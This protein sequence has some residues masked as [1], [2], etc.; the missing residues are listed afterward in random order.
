[1]HRE[2]SLVSTRE[3]S[4]SQL[5]RA[6]FLS[7]GPLRLKVETDASVSFLYSSDAGRLLSGRGA[8]ELFKVQAGLLV[9]LRQKEMKVRLLSTTS[10]E[11]S[12]RPP[13][14]LQ[15]SSTISLARGPPD[16]YVRRV[17]MANRSVAPARVRALT[18]CDPTSLNFRKE[19]DPPGEIGLNAFNRGDHV[20]MD[21]VGDTAGARVVGLNP[22]PSI[23]YMTRERQRAL[24]L[25][26]TGELPE[27]ISGLSGPVMVLA[28]Q[29][30]DLP[31]GGSAELCMATLYDGA[32][33]GAALARL[34]DLLGVAPAASARGA[35]GGDGAGPGTHDPEDQEAGP[36]FRCSSPA[37]SS[38]YL[39]AKS[40]L[41]SIEGEED[42]F[43]RLSAGVA[44]GLLRPDYFEHEF[45]AL[46]GG[47][48]K[49][50]SLAR[51]GSAEQGVLETALFVMNSCVY[52]SQKGDV[53]LTKRWYP[54]LK[55]AGAALAAAA[56]G[57]LVQTNASRP[58]G[59]RR[60]LETGFPTGVTSEVNLIVARALN[61][62]AAAAYA[63]GRGT[64]SAGFRDANVK[65]V[66]SINE[67][68]KDPKTGN[69]VLNIDP[70]GRV[71]PEVT[72]DQAV[73][74]YYY[75]YDHNLASSA[76]QR[77]LEK[78]F[79]SGLGPR[80]VPTSNP[81]YYHP[82]YGEG[83]LGSCWT[84]VALSHALLAYDSGY[85]S[86][87][88]L[89]LEKV[90]RVVYADWEKYGGAPGEFPYWFVEGERRLVGGSGSDPVAAAR[91][92]EAVVFGELG[93]TRT[94]QG[95]KLSPPS[96]SQLRWASMHA[97][98]LGESGSLF[99]GRS[100]GRVVLI[101]SSHHPVGAEGLL[102][103]AGCR[104][105]AT[106]APVEALAFWDESSMLIC[107][108]TSEGWV[109]GSGPH[110]FTLTVPLAAGLFSSSLYVDLQEFNKDA[111]LWNGPER[112]RLQ[113]DLQ[114]RVEL[115]PGEWSA[116]RLA[117]ATKT[118]GAQG[119]A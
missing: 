33:L 71:H 61:E 7:R 111:R 20:V 45:D 109:P 118:Q 82:T 1:M 30:V 80:C 74:L 103:F 98:T 60:R 104:R 94:P 115:V 87:G 100:S 32:S 3:Y 36:V 35:T 91:F 5:K 75:P 85:P 31:P 47:Q 13:D 14:G 112:R 8:V 4:N 12:Y 26:S 34:P 83:Q 117:P 66:S 6:L 21:D 48:R 29:D 72:A 53:K 23:I 88:G 19:R 54:S 17:S 96:G 2:A 92:V 52:L 119:K 114:I 64:D 101:A 40:A 11:F 59:W 93:V 107:A 106:P 10:V 116:Y 73:G 81:L 78:D 110:S 95:P 49:D 44:L 89:Q 28:Q 113:G 24:D 68:L 37:V 38:A 57:G 42:E 63:A 39:W 55:K 41:H 22:R 105:L 18:I 56:R 43:E 102:R 15:F 79:E 70:K 27:N 51:Q 67:R 108:G 65:M 76:V 50:G 9:P 58:E 16:G 25:L 99:V 97:L 62:L 69:L 90:A 77:M 84:R 86:I 46:R